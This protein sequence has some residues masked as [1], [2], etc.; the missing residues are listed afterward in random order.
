ME[1][2]VKKKKSLTSALVIVAHIIDVVETKKIPTLN[3]IIQY[4]TGRDTVRM[5]PTRLCT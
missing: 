2:V 3:I 1:A 5:S 4:V